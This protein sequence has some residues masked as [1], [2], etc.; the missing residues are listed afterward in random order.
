MLLTRGEIHL[1]E[2]PM[3][4]TFIGHI[5]NNLWN[6]I[7]NNIWNNIWNLPHWKQYLKPTI[8]GPSQFKGNSI[9]DTPWF[10]FIF[11]HKIWAISKKILIT[12][13]FF[14]LSDIAKKK[15]ATAKKFWFIFFSINEFFRIWFFF[16]KNSWHFFPHFYQ[17]GNL[18]QRDLPKK[19]SP[20]VQ[21]SLG[22]VFNLKEQLSDI[23][24]APKVDIFM[25]F[26][27]ETLRKKLAVSTGIIDQCQ[28]QKKPVPRFSSEFLGIIQKLLRQLFRH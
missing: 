22:I 14:N 6:N 21:S 9:W 16:R 7:R 1:E 27:I 8:I 13:V 24:W 12:S 25:T 26:K 18:D 20:S 4:N 15:L 2:C 28:G 17:M 3:F 10:F 11:F 5:W 23:F 19:S